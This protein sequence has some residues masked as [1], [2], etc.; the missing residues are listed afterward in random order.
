MKKLSII[1]TLLLVLGGRASAQYEFEYIFDSIK[2]ETP[3]VGF[4]DI[5]E[6]D[7]NGFVLYGDDMT[8]YNHFASCIYRFSS[9]GELVKEKHFHD[10][11]LKAGYFLSDS[12]GYHLLKDNDGGYRMFMAYNPILDT[13]DVGYVP[14][15]FDSK[16]VMNKLDDDFELEYS[17]EMSVCIDTIDWDSLWAN[18]ST[19]D[20]RPHIQIGTVMDDGG[21]GFIISYEKYVGNLKELGP[22]C[23][24]GHLWTHG[25]DSTF[26]L[27]TDRDL[28]VTLQGFYEHNRCVSKMYHRNHLLYDSEQDRFIYITSNDWYQSGSS[29]KSLYVHLF[30][31]EFNFIEENVMAGTSGSGYHCIDFRDHRVQTEGMTLKRTSSHTTLIGAAATTCHFWNSI[32]HKDCVAVCLEINDK[33]IL[34]DSMNFAKMDLPLFANHRTAVPTFNSMDFIDEDR[35]F[36]G[37][38]PYGF[39]SYIF[40]DNTYQYFILRMLDRN[41]NTMDEVY[42]DMGK[43]STALWVFNLKATRDGG[44][45][46]AGHFWNYVETPS[47]NNPK[48]FRSVVKKF[49]PEAFDGIEE[50]H[51]NGLKVAFAYPNPGGNVLNIRTALR[52]VHVAVYDMNGKLICDQEI[53]DII[54]SVNVESWPSGIYIWKVIKDGSEAESGKWVKE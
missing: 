6:L 42:Y 14:G 8:E 2:D 47:V 37:A 30:D 45:I 15:I 36:F 13:A 28:N 25:Y 52:N 50:A 22:V 21:E 27:K 44:C 31:G 1:F 48:A 32:L 18:C 41:L 35:I 9:A 3:C 34:V 7:D 29:K 38:T 40:F 23:P 39:F 19:A 54:T 33:A 53:S 26:F 10:Q 49:P 17:R 12:E 4:Y 16:I 5:I 24:Q 43:D 51:D 20:Y 46:I 11:L